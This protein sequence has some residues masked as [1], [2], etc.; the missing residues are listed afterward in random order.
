MTDALSRLSRINRALD[1]KYAGSELIGP[2]AVCSTERGDTKGWGILVPG[3]GEWD[4]MGVNGALAQM[5]ELA[6]EKHIAHSVRSLFPDLAAKVYPL[7]EQLRSGHSAFEDVEVRAAKTTGEPKDWLV[8]YSP[9]RA[10]GGAFLAVVA[11]VRRR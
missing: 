10:P 5:N 6:A 8:T 7:F 2:G 1:I 3:A 4:F 9:V 11:L